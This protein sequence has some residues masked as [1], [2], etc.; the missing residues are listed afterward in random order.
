[1]G[2]VLRV[3]KIIE[4]VMTPVL[5]TIPKTDHR[6]SFKILTDRSKGF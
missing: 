4:I 3:I 1:M 2:Y 5:E 6:K